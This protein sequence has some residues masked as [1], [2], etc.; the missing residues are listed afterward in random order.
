[1]RRSRPARLLRR[2][3]TCEVLMLVEAAL[4]AS[5]R[6]SE[7]TERALVAELIETFEAVVF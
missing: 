7:A 6:V 5:Q 1:V 4:E 3:F 2:T